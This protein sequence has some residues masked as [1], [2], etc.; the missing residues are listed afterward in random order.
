MKKI[1]CALL[2]LLPLTAFAYP[3]EVEKQLNGAEVSYTTLDVDQD[4]GAIMLYNLGQ[5]PAQCTAV[6]RNG[7]E[8]PRT[9]KALIEAGQSANLSVKFNRNIIKLRIKLTCGLK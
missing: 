7:P 4:L 9:R 2:A 1:C 3:I 6:F 5:T 8:A